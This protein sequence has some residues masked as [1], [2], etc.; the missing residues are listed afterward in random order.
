VA[1]RYSRGSNLERAQEYGLD[2]AR[3]DYVKPLDIMAKGKLRGLLAHVTKSG[4]VGLP[5][6]LATYEAGED[7]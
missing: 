4:V 3:P 1:S 5:A 7:R 2:K 6:A